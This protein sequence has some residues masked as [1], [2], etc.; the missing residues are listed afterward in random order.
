[1][2]ACR[3]LSPADGARLVRSWQQL[4]ARPR[5]ERSDKDSRSCNHGCNQDRA[6]AL[7][8]WVLR[9]YVLWVAVYGTEDRPL[10]SVAVF[11]VTRRQVVTGSARYALGQRSV[12]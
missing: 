5:R 8:L 10:E 12:C 3:M 1:M 9:S 6:R 2:I 11:F 4:G 7:S